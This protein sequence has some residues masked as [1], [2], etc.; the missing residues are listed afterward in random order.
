MNPKAATVAT[1]IAK[2]N[3]SARRNA[4]ALRTS[5]IR[6]QFEADG[7]DIDNQ[8]SGARGVQFAAQVA[9]LH[10][11]NIGLRHEFEIPHILKQHRSGHNLPGAAH[12]IL[13]ELK[14]P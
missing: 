2:E 4:R 7:S 12:E 10:V 9:D 1:E 14:F 6:I 8:T 13:Q 5:S 11:D 3:A